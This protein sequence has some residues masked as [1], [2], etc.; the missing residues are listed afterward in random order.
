MVEIQDYVPTGK[1]AE[2]QMVDPTT[3]VI[4]TPKPKLVDPTKRKGDRHKKRIRIALVD[5]TMLMELQE[6]SAATGHTINSLVLAC[7]K[8]VLPTLKA[9]LKAKADV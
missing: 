3:Q 8:H 4:K 5:P 1:W 2:K 9:N 6:V 7:V